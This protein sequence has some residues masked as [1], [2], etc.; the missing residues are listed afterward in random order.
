KQS[1]A[2]DIWDC[3][4][5]WWHL[6]AGRPPIFADSDGPLP[7]IRQL[8]PDVHPSLARAIKFCTS[9]NLSERA[10]SF[11]ALV[12]MLGASTPADGRSLAAQLLGSGR[13]TIRP[14]WSWQLQN[15]MRHSAQPMLAVAACAALVLVAILPLRL[16]PRPAQS[17]VDSTAAMDSHRRFEEPQYHVALG[18][19]HDM[20]DRAV[21][22]VNYQTAELAAAAAT[23]ASSTPPTQIIELESD[24]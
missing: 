2:D 5:L 18:P 9:H 11:A 7:D 1:I 21:R 4:A 8:A 13:W 22:M 10:Q 3:G 16:F 15:T 14:N 23:K 6:L 17:P 20:A 12:E 24:T 19:A